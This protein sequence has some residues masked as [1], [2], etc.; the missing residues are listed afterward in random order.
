[1]RTL[2]ARRKCLRLPFPSRIG[3]PA[4][5][6]AIL[7]GAGFGTAE[8]QTGQWRAS[9]DSIYLGIGTTSPNYPMDVVA[10]GSQIRLGNT[11]SNDGMFLFGFRPEHFSVAGG[12]SHDGVEWTAR[13]PQAAIIASWDGGITFSGD[14]GL[15]VGSSYLPTYRMRIMPGGNVGMYG[16]VEIA[17]NVGIG[18]SPGRKLTVKGAFEVTATTGEFNKAELLIEAANDIATISAART[19]SHAVTHLRFTTQNSGGGVEVMRLT[20]DGNVGIGTTS[21]NAKL[22]VAGGDAAVTTQGNGIILRAT[23]GANCY[24]ITVNNEG[25]LSTAPVSCP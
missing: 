17:G 9:G 19:A 21:P 11:A 18:T 14:T 23:D 10:S 16:D 1:M 12:A 13:A 7:L 15:T 20:S 8:A 5:G 3:A 25:T 4:I 6:T 2:I 24:R 22:E